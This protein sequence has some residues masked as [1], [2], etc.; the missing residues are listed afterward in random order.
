MQEPSTVE[1]VDPVLWSLDTGGVHEAILTFDHPPSAVDVVA[2][3]ASG[4]VAHRY[5]ALPMMAVQGTAAQ[6]RGLLGLPGLQ[7]IYLDRLVE[8][9]TGESEPAAQPA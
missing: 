4:V 6:L 9:Y 8:S 3:E 2:I 5:N 1:T 7:S